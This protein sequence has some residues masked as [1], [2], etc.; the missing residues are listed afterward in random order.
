MPN[1][2]MKLKCNLSD[3]KI[4]KQLEVVY[5][6]VFCAWGIIVKSVSCIIT[7]LIF[8]ASNFCLCLVS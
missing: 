7:Y 5:N 1:N 6:N 4:F 2:Q 8:C 3:F